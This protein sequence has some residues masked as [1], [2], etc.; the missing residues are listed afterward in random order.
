MLFI[1]PFAKEPSP[2]KPY[3]NLIKITARKTQWEHYLMSL[4]IMY[5]V[6]FR[7]HGKNFVAK[8]IHLQISLW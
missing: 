7:R 6:I 1:Q 2:C 3:L 4:E 8:T 5:G